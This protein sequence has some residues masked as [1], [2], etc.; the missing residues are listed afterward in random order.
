MCA[1]EHILNL[2]TVTMCL[3]DITW[4]Q[5]HLKLGELICSSE[6]PGQFVRKRQTFIGRVYLQ[7][8]YSSG[9][10]FRKLYTQNQDVTVE[11]FG[12]FS[13]EIYNYDASISPILRNSKYIF[14]NSDYRL[15]SR[16]Q[17]MN[18]RLS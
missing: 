1:Y 10:I 9:D 5:L 12:E 15:C 11:Q 18:H 3:V 6:G 8:P 4:S 17:S 2:N 7:I 14:D 13:P 16:K